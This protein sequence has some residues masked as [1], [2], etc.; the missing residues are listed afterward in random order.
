MFVV[1]GGLLALYMYEMISD[2]GM[3]AYRPRV[4][5]TLTFPKGNPRCALAQW[6]PA[7]HKSAR[8]VWVSTLFRAVSTR[9]MFVSVVGLL[10][11]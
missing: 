1:V 2:P 8:G 3:G 6:D 9:W 7:N 5:R 10:E 4:M 11:L